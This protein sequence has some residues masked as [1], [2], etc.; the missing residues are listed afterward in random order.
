MNERV[1]STGE[2]IMTKE[3]ESTGRKS[4]PNA[5]LFTKN[6]T[7]SYAVQPYKTLF[8]R[9]R[10]KRNEHLKANKKEDKRFL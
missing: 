8:R 1:L 3:S 7:Y 2:K 5:I 10:A 4:S 9:E 6:L